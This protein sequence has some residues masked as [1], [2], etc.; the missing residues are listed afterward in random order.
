MYPFIIQG[1]SL[2][3]V[4]DGRTSTINRETHPKFDAIL[5]AIRAGE[6]VLAYRSREGR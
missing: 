5:D 6:L 4:I 3:I 2:L 1:D